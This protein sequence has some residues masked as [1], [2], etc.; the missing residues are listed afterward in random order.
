MN[1]ITW[2]MNLKNRTKSAIIMSFPFAVSIL[3]FTIC[4]LA[5]PNHREGGYAMLGTIALCGFIVAGV[6]IGDKKDK[7]KILSETPQVIPE[8]EAPHDIFPEIY[9]WKKNDR[10]QNEKTEIYTYIG[11]NEDGIVCLRQATEYYQNTCRT[12]TTPNAELFTMSII[13]VMK[14]FNN[15]S[16]LE[17]D[18]TEPTGRSIEYMKAIETFQ[19]AYEEMKK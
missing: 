18:F 9:Y 15:V 19:L 6:E 4:L 17:R 2:F 16:L 5:S 12:E 10:L 7:P 11:T 1:V 8:T 14:K 3:A 13:E